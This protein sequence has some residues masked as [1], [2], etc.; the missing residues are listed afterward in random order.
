MQLHIFRG[1]LFGQAQAVVNIL[2]SVLHK[3]HGF[4]RFILQAFDHLPDV[5]S[6]AGCSCGQGSSLLSITDAQEL[7][8]QCWIT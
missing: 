1:C 3:T 4:L 2:D 5:V 7:I 6:G 8:N